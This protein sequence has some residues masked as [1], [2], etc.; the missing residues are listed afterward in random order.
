MLC[1]GSGFAAESDPMGCQNVLSLLLLA[2]NSILAISR[3]GQ[4]PN[5]LA[6]VPPLD[7]MT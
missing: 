3:G 1:A 4:L 6:A 5:S 2:E 7:S